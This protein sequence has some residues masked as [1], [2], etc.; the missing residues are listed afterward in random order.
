MDAGLA[1]AILFTNLGLGIPSKHTWTLPGIRYLFTHALE[2]DV[3]TLDMSSL[4]AATAELQSAL[5]DDEG[6]DEEDRHR[7]EPQAMQQWTDLTHEPPQNN[8]DRHSPM[9]DAPTS[10]RS[11]TPLN[12]QHP[13]RT[14]KGGAQPTPHTD[15]KRV[16]NF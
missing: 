8:E 5:Q 16:F 6:N 2:R 12:H 13:F 4:A 14:R 15:G 11:S 7:P 10:A 9:R 3:E 1:R